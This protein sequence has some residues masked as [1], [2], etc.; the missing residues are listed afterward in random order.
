MSGILSSRKPRLLIQIPGVDNSNA[1]VMLWIVHSCRRCTGSQIVTHWFCPASTFN[2]AVLE[3]DGH[4]KLQPNS[5]G[6]ISS[7]LKATTENQFINDENLEKS[8]QL[9][10]NWFSKQQRKVYL[11][12][13]ITTSVTLVLLSFLLN[14]LS[15][16]FFARKFFSNFLNIGLKWT[17]WFFSEIMKMALKNSCAAIILKTL[18]SI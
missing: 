4:D 1:F 16:L 11:G 18:S 14:N 12:N 8:F 13:S 9:N 15:I 7:I 6:I 10:G 3:V 5:K 2:D 17:D